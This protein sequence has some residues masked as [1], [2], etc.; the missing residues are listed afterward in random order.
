MKKNKCQICKKYFDDSDTYEYRGFLSC[1]KHF[2]ELCKKVDY[3]R[4]EVI[5]ENEASVNSQR[6]GEWQNG[7]YK[8]MKVDAGGRP[9]TKIKEPMRTKEYED[10]IL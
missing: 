4:E 2:D 1:Q 7:G 5:E 6:N 3:K 9:I 10:G 8:T